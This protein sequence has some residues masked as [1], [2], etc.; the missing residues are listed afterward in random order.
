[1]QIKVTLFNII[2][3]AFGFKFILWKKINY[4]EQS[5]KINVS[6]LLVAVGKILR[7][8]SIQP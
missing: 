7:S 5:K 8:R 6:N 2:S 3:I 1:M 4:K